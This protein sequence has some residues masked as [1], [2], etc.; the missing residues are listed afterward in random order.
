ME[1]ANKMVL[2]NLEDMITTNVSAENIKDTLTD[3]YMDYSRVSL[4]NPDNPFFSKEEIANKLV[5]L[6]LLIE[7]FNARK[8]INT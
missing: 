8:P 4:V 6:K 7:C 2:S 3:I 1:N 5:D